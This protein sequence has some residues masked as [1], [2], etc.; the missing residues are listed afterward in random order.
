MRFF[1]FI[2]DGEILLKHEFGI[3]Q[4]APEPEERYDK[5]EPLKYN[6]ISID[7]RYVEEIDS[8]LN[9]VDFYWHTLDMPARGID[10]TGITLIPPTSLQEF[11]AIIEYIDEFNE[12][13]GLLKKALSESKW[14][15]HYGL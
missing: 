3:M 8:Y 11:I 12:L 7:D 13:K 6:C 10:Y 5:Y 4:D 15:I 9:N 2:K 14:V 1:N